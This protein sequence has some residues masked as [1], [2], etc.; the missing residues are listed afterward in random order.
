M[1]PPPP[2]VKAVGEHCTAIQKACEAIASA[3]GQEFGVARGT[4]VLKS[5]TIIEE[6]IAIVRDIT[7]HLARLAVNRGTMTNRDIAPIEAALK[8]LGQRLGRLG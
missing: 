1:E 6:A 3:I 8:H 5:D 7:S 4:D 2:E